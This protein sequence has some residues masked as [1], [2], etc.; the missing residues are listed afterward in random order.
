M[1]SW[2]V[3]GSS[4]RTSEFI[5]TQRHKDTESATE[6]GGVADKGPRRCP[7]RGTALPTEGGGVALG[8]ARRGRSGQHGRAHEDDD[9]HGSALPTPRAGRA[10]VAVRRNASHQGRS[11]GRG[12]SVTTDNG[13]EFL[14]Q[15]RLDGGRK[16]FVRTWEV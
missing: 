2:S 6:G 12:G 3:S 14:D 8:G 1:L 7:R 16:L 9:R 11:L 5:L 15:P 4:L 10:Q 13:C